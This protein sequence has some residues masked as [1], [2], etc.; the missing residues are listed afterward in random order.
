MARVLSALGDKDAMRLREATHALCSTL[1]AFSTVAG[2]AASNLEDEAASGQIEKCIPLV[3][4]L[5]SICSELIE[6]TRNLSMEKL[7][8]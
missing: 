4:R 6:L 3:T 2:S 8:S 7:G 5:E 1:A